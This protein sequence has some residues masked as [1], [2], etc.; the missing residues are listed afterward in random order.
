MLNKKIYCLFHF[1]LF[2]LLGS[3]QSQLFPFLKQ[4]ELSNY[5]ISLVYAGI[6]F[7]FMLGQI[8]IGILCDYTNTYKRWMVCLIILSTIA[9]V[10]LF[11]K[12][13]HIGIYMVAS[14]LV[15]SVYKVMA[16]LLETWTLQEESKQY[17]YIRCYGAVG[18][19][20]GSW[21]CG[22]VLKDHVHL[23]IYMFLLFCDSLILYCLHH[24]EVK[25]KKKNPICFG[26]IKKLLCTRRYMFVVLILFLLYA[27]GSVDQY[28]VVAKFSHIHASKL[29]ISTKYAI[30]SAMEIPVYYFMNTIFKKYSSLQL[31]RIASIGYGIKFFLYGYFQAVYKLLWCTTLQMITL[32]IVLLAGKKLVSEVTPSTVFASSQMIA[33]AV[34]MGCSGFVTPFVCMKGIQCVG[35]DQTL[36]YASMLTIAPYI[37]LWIFGYS[38]KTNVKK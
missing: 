20:I 7:S 35:Y 27:I 21:L 12:G 17:G 1:I 2:F 31:L 26:D 37:L 9:T 34:F 28:V 29:Q 8:I 5:E 36:Y 6:A 15:G 4:L 14:V 32:P 23:S 19:T 3:A 22:Y 33:M 10:I 16:N 38:I 24:V 25:K 18:F 30:Q 13:F 11:T